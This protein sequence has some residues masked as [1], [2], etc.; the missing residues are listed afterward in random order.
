MFYSKA[1]LLMRIVFLLAPERV[2]GCI[3]RDIPLCVCVCVCIGVTAQNYT[4]TP[5]QGF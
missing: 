5:T 3:Q 2:R 1:R 4:C